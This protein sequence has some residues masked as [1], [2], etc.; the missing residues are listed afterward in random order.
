MAKSKIQPIHPF[1]A[2]MAP[3][4]ALESLSGLDRGSSVLDPMAGSGVV[5]RQAMSLGHTAMGVDTDPL[6]ILMARVWTTP[7]D[8]DCVQSLTERVLEKVRATDPKMVALPWMDDDNETREFVRF[9]FGEA[10]RRDLRLLSF[11]IEHYGSG[12]DGVDPAALNVLRL[13]LSRIIVTKASCASL[14]RDTSHSRPHRVR[15]VSDY[16]VLSGFDKAVSL[17]RKCLS[18]TPPTGVASVLQGDARRLDMVGDGT[19][20]LVLTSPPYLNAIDYMRG[21]RLA[22][23]WLGY[24]LETLRCIRSTNIGAERAPDNQ[25]DNK[26]FVDIKNAMGN[27][28]QL[29]MRVQ[30]IVDR[31]V[32]DM[33]WMMTEVNRVLRPGG[34]ATIVIGNNC[35]KDIFV[36]NSDGLG[37][38]AVMAG[39]VPTRSSER[40]LPEHRRYLPVRTEARLAK[41]MRTECILSFV[42]KAA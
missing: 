28:G 42:R 4:I 23:V 6:A 10:Q 24:N 9:W 15:L 11:V 25:S 12:R 3:D 38:A 31:Y 22:L 8:D 33:F 39:L 41:R 2:R 7:V 5:L 26:R 13:A 29:P 32:A 20:D 16:D 19:V 34:K 37:E 1:P 30:R 18:R 17:I 27:I 40:E 21:H 35:I 36:R 14:A